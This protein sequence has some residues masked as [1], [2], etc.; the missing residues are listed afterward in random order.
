LPIVIDQANA[1]VAKLPALVKELLSD[2][3]I[4]PALKPLPR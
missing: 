4:F 2:G 1:S 3:A